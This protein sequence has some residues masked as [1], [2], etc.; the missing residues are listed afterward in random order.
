M[1]NSYEPK[2]LAIYKD[3]V[4]KLLE[5]ISVK[6][7]KLEVKPNDTLVVQPNSPGL[8]FTRAYCEFLAENLNKLLPVGCNVLICEFADVDFRLEEKHDSEQ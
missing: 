6:I 3:R 8:I 2:E 7:T 1:E 5:D 4:A